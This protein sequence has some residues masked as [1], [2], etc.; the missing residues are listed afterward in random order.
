MR[1]GVVDLLVDAPLRGWQEYLYAAYFRKQFTSIMPQAVSVWCRQLGHEVYYTTYYGVGDPARLLP[2]DLDVVFVSTYTQASALAYALAK[3]FRKQGTLSVIGGPHAKSFPHDCLRF[4]D[5]VVQ[6]CDKTLID[7]ILRHRFDPPAMISSGRVLTDFP[8]VEDRMPE[9]RASAFVAGRPILMSVVPMLASIGCPYRCDFCV[10]WNTDYV[11]L[12][13]DRLEADLRYLSDNHPR[14]L[15]AFHDPNFAVRFDRTMD[16]MERIAPER[17]NGY[18]MESSLSILKE[19]RLKRLRATNCVYVA[20]G[21]ESWSDYSNKVGAS[22]KEGQQKLEQVVAHFRSLGRFVPG[23]QANFLFGAD[24]DRGAEPVDLTKEFIRRLPLVWP[25]VNIPTPFG[26]TPLHAKYV[27]EG[28]I[29]GALPFAFYYNPYLA[30]MLKHYDPLSYYDHL[31]DMHAL[32]ASRRML[33][34]RLIARCRPAIRFIHGL[35]TFAAG[36]EL[37]A[38]RHV[39]NQLATDPA[40]AAFHEGRTQKLPAYYHSAIRARLGRYAELLSP[41]D[42]IPLSGQAA[43]PPAATARA[44]ARRTLQ[45]R[46]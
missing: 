43:P 1:V 21:I 2:D 18:I 22:G 20:P 3:I 12:P 42:L 34:K 30:I 32:L 7:D 9:I 35:R 11:A 23:M 25:T 4:F 6:E 13:E 8:S 17:R 36:K 40:F 14:L 46:Q 33:A 27:A 44:V 45:L 29:L 10:D 24:V 38:F 39:R 37:A 26:A 16:V 15:V 31:I 41:A 5:L 28:R 19:S